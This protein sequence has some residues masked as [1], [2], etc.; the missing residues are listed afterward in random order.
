MCGTQVADAARHKHWDATGLLFTVQNVLEQKAGEAAKVIEGT[1]E[2]AALP[3]P[4]VVPDGLNEV[5]D[6][7]D[8]A[9]RPR[10]R[11]P[12]KRKVPWPPAA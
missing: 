3:A 1:V 5:M 11:K 7:A 4:D 8:T 6:A 12:R 10:E 9:A 2:I